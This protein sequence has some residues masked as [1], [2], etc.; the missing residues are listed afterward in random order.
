[1]TVLVVST[2]VVLAGCATDEPTTGAPSSPSAGTASGSGSGTGKQSK[3]FV[4]A[5]YD[6]QLALL[7][8]AP[9]GPAGKPWEQAL[10]PA[11]VKTAKFSEPGPHKICF[12][13]AGLNNPWRQVGFKTMQ[14]E[15]DTHRDRISEFVHVDAEGKDQKQIADI[16]DL[17][18]K[19]CDALIVSPNTTATLTPAV[20]AA[21]RKG[22]PVVVFDRGVDTTC[23]V[24]VINPIGGYGFG[25]VAAE[26]V[27]RKM[28]RGGKVLALRI[29][30]GVDVLE[31]RWSAA[32]VAF[33]TAG[34]DVVGVEFTDGDPAKTK[35]IVNDYIQRY[36]TID[37][38]WM[39][40]GAV[41]GAAVEA[42]EDAGKPV[43][44]ING[45]DQLDFLKMWKDKKLTAI[46]P[47]YPTYQWRTPIIA[48]LK[49]LDGEQVPNPWKLPQPTITQDN[50]EEY[51]DPTMPPLH[52]AMCGCTDLPGYP[53]RW[54]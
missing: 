14:A 1:M 27:A 13:N 53:K 2:L 22:L 12:S 23:P 31:T 32:K 40:A 18:G 28:K 38:V 30:P 43:P 8:T 29:L 15:V 11:M 46:A 10:D 37:G 49:I 48:A 45:E 5:D 50:L 33:D 21:C 39:D 19:G 34:V 17:L 6:K 54:Q 4:R 3:F 20:E 25:H 41:A 9:T 35:K 26:F 42:F 16:N 52:Y 36:G 44:P 24:T 51:V 7:D 47:T